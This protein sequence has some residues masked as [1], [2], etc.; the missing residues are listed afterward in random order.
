MLDTVYSHLDRRAAA[1][2]WLLVALVA[3]GRHFTLALNVSDSLS[4]T[5]FLVEKGGPAGRGELV[6]F[7]HG[8]GGPFTRGALFLKRVAG[9]PNSIV[10][11]QD[12][13]NGY[14]D[15]FVDGRYVGRAKP[16]SKVGLPLEPGPTGTI[17]QGRYYMTAPHPDSFDSRYALV[18]WVAD[19]R[20][21][22][23]AFRVF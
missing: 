21:V 13:G 16:K 3:F 4:G 23:R 2:L 8:G 20:I 12:T 9:M 11:H 14:Y 19:A 1:Y 15:Y 18:G 10:T 7:R 5:I 6:A 22:G 17:P